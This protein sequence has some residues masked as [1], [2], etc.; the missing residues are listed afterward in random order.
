M[1]KFDDN[2]RR[3][4]TGFS[5]KELVKGMKTILKRVVQL[6]KEKPAV[7]GD[8][9]LLVNYYWWKYHRKMF[10]LENFEDLMKLPSSESIT[11][12]FR[13]AVELGEIE[14]TGKIL[15][16]REQRESAMR[17]LMKKDGMLE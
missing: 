12:A 14:P 6:S 4:D 11:R 15:K 10:G 8:Y 7:K 3:L 16:R 5:E 9:R 13:K 2:Q 1:K 17:R